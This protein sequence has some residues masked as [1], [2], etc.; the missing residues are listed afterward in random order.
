MPMRPGF[1]VSL[2]APLRH[3]PGMLGS[4]AGLHGWLEILILAAVQYDRQTDKTKTTGK[5][6]SSA[7]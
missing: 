5:E 1:A 4:E 2:S 6:Q 7:H 3:C